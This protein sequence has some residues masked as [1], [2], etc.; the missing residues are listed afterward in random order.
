MYHCWL[1]IF[2]CPSTPLVGHRINLIMNLLNAIILQYACHTER[3]RS[4][5]NMQNN[6]KWQ[7]YTRTTQFDLLKQQIIANI[8]NFLRQLQ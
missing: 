7:F 6:L 8:L 1:L 5:L 2:F 3:S 4:G